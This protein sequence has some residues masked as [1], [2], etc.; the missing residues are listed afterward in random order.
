MKS[1]TPRSDSHRRRH[2]A[3]GN[4]SRRLKLTRTAVNQLP[5]LMD[6]QEKLASSA[7]PDLEQELRPRNMQPPLHAPAIQTPC[8]CDLV[9][10]RANAPNYP[11]LP[12]L[13]P[14]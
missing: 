3:K 1:S 9:C 5:Y 11:L 7:I 14:D 6:R 10:D 13:P 4:Q 8:L 2:G 12:K